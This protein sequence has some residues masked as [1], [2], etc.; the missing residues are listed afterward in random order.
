MFDSTIQQIEKCAVVPVIALDRE[1][2]A[3]Q[4]AEALIAGG[5]PIAEVTFR[6]SAAEASI[7]TMAK[8]GDMLVGAGTVLD[9]D[10]VKRAVD[11]GATFIVS[12]GLNPK[13]VSYC[14]ENQIPITPGCLTPTEIELAMEHGL[15]VVKFFPAESFGGLKTIQALAAPYSMMRFIPTGG[16]SEAQLA[17]YLAFKPIVAV[18][19]GW[20]VS[21]P[22][23][24]EGKFDEITRL[25]RRASEIARA[26]GR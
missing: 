7:R 13:V 3:A 14:V 16:I 25:A 5:L 22:L 4:L 2:D 26:A 19:G 21:K 1:A 10:T 11:A 9:V 17:S 20:M 6:T 23:I 24:A 18:G 15:R 8:R 12:P